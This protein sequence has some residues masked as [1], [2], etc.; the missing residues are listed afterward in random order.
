MVTFFPW[1]H[2]MVDIIPDDV[3]D[4]L[5][6]ISSLSWEIDPSNIQLVMSK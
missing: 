3:G 2:G 5:I 1:P 6:K 4:F